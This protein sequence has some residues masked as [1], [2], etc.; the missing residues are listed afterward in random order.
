MSDDVAIVA[1]VGGGVIGRSWAVAFAA[2]GA[3]VRIYDASPS[4][5]RNAQSFA[6]QAIADLRRFGLC[7]DAGEV[8]AR[9]LFV[10]RLETAVADA[11]YVQESIAEDAALKADLFARIDEMSR[12][13]AVLASSTS[14]IPASEFL[15]TLRGRS[16]CIVAHPINPPHLMPVV[17][18]CPAPFTAPE[19]VTR[20]VRMMESIGREP[21][22]LRKEV[23]GFLVNR[24]QL[25]LIGEALHLIGEGY[26]SA[27]DLDRAVRHSLGLRW[28]LL[29]PLEAGHLNADG[30]YYDYMKKFE[31]AVKQLIADLRVDYDWN[32]S[33]YQKISEELSSRTPSEEIPEKQAERDRALLALLRHLKGRSNRK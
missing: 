19:T 6:T 24:L 7:E 30:G 14:T 17:E 11:G 20:T 32:E 29:G 26:C 15:G 13:D 16:R 25:A 21:V 4:S 18:I 23:P 10:D 3:S 8:S 12:P 28:A 22:L 2:G 27:S 33:H 9:L 5:L 31:P 1:C